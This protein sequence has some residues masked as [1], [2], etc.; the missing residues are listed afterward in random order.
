MALIVKKR[1]FV[2][3]SFFRTIDNLLNGSENSEMVEKTEKE[4]R[5]FQP[6]MNVIEKENSYEIQFALAGWTNKD[7]EI[8][9]DDSILVVSGNKNME[10]SQENYYHNYEF[11]YGKFEVKFQLP[12][13]VDVVVDA[14]MKNGILKVRIEKPVEKETKKTIEVK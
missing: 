6:K 9:V 12:E 5:T 2:P 14:E 10:Y 8:K 13:G 11:D 4:I 1:E 3:Q 7:I